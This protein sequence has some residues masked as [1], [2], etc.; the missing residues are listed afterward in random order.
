MQ[1][2]ERAAFV[3]N[4]VFYNNGGF[5]Q[6]SQLLLCLYLTIGVC[7]YFYVPKISGHQ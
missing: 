1:S 3:P 5:I 7:Y 6:F 4:S 2:W